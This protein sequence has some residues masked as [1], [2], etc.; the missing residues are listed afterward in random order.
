MA[1]AIL[2]VTDLAPVGGRSSTTTWVPL[3]IFVLIRIFHS[4]ITRDHPAH[5]GVAARSLVFS[6]QVRGH[7][8]R[9]HLHISGVNVKADRIQCLRD[10]DR[11]APILEF[12]NGAEDARY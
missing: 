12:G 5:V 9:G 8:D 10:G 6:S 4:S 11:D 7:D 3:R 1:T 2:L